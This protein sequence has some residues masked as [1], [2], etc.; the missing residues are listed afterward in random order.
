MTAPFRCAV[1]SSGRTDEL[2]GTAST[3]RAFLLVEEPGP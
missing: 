2:A 1:S 3:V